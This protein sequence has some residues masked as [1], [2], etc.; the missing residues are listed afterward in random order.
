[1]ADGHPAQTLLIVE[2]DRALS[3]MLA[4]LFTEEGYLVDV[5]HDGQQGLHR[6]LTGRYDAVIVDRGL[7]VMDGADLVAVLRSRGVSTPALVLTARG[8]VADRVEGLDA[9]AQDYL[10]KPFEIPELLARVRALLRRP[11]GRSTL[12]VGGLCLDRLTRRVTG[13]AV[14]GDGVELSE[15][16]AAL[17][18]VLMSAPRQVFTRG[19]LL[20]RVFNGVD[21]SGAVDTYVHYLRRKLGRDVVRTVHGTGYRLGAG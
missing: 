21:S 4:E 12:R 2:D 19:Q 13:S 3:V 5:A 14:G 11:D 18:G 9:G 20:E 10:L 8:S 15:R 16:E 6:G 17:L 1:M 7:P